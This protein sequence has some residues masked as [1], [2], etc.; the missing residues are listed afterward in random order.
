M[1][2]AYKRAAITA[3]VISCV[4]MLV[5]LLPADPTTAE[6]DQLAQ[7]ELQH[8]LVLQL[9]TRPGGAV[10]SKS[11]RN[12]SVAWVTAVADDNYLRPALVLATTIELFSCIKQRVVLLGPAVTSA[13]ETTLQQMGFQT[14]RPPINYACPGIDQGRWRGIFLRFSAFSMTSFRRLIYVDGDMMLLSN[15]DDVLDTIQWPTDIAAAQFERPMTRSQLLTV[16]SDN[17]FNSGLMAFMPQP[18]LEALVANELTRLG[19]GL[20]QPLLNHVFAQKGW[21]LHLIPFSY[22]VRKINYHPMRAFHFAGS[23]Q[24]KIWHTVP[25]ERSVRR[26]IAICSVPDDVAHVFWH[27]FYRGQR[28]FGITLI[29][30]SD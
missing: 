1:S 12:E 24:M 22:N 19:C 15:I 18:G 5:L 3:I 30:S 20:D 4:M 21:D 7:M 2:P 17:G 11:F 6:L 29:P 8:R 16:W 10:C 13:A 28:M 14:V 25:D 23:P 27:Y 9:S 26:D